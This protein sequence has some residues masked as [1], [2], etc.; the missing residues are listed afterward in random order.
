MVS[1][2]VSLAYNPWCMAYSMLGIRWVMVDN[3]RE[4]FWAWKGVGGRK[5]YLGLISLTIFWVV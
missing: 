5:K 1:L 2:M 4:E 3:V